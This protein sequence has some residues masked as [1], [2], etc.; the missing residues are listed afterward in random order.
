VLAEPILNYDF[1]LAAASS[2]DGWQIANNYCMWVGLQS[3]AEPPYQLLVRPEQKILFLPLKP[4]M[5]HMIPAGSPHRLAHRFAPWRICDADTIYLR[6]EEPEGIY[7]ALLT[8]TTQ[9][10]NEDH[11][12]WLCPFCGCEIAR[13][14]FDTRHNGLVAFWPFQLERVRAYNAAPKPCPGCGKTHP[15]AYGFDPK[16]DNVAEQAARAAG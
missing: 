14:A 11:I 8:A 13:E 12:L 6:V 3:P 15:P 7:T 10:V 5:M 4:R 1:S 9:S 16:Q 2:A